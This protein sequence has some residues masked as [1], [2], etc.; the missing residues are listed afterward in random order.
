M[1]S[2]LENK[3]RISTGATFFNDLEDLEKGARPSELRLWSDDKKI[4]GICVVYTTG[5]ENAHGQR[6]GNPQHVLK[7]DVDEIITEI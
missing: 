2:L 4:K 6:N 5:K 7:L 1:Q 3:N